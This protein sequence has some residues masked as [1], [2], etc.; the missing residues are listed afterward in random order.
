MPSVLE[1]LPVKARRGS[2]SRCHLLTDGST[3][4]VA[5]RLTSLI[6]P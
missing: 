6:V 5:T 1:R 3:E 2:K 4:I